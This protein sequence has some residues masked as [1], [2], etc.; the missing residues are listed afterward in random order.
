M[1]SALFLL[2]GALALSAC[3]KSDTESVTIPDGEGGS[4]T[5]SK[6]DS[7]TT[8]TGA[9]GEETTISSNTGNNKLPAYVPAYPGS[10]AMESASIKTGEGE[11]NTASFT[12]PDPASKVI[13]FY[14]EKLTSGGMKIMME[15][16]S[17]DGS[18]IMANRDGKEDGESAVVT[19]NT[20]GGDT[21]VAIV[22]NIAAQ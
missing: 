15:T 13:A 4:T 17:T 7:T 16:N 19:V 8:I 3:G 10:K 6:S 21:K 5:F 12:T 14:K 2:C 9:D 11:M 20:E 18:M 22:S 1:K